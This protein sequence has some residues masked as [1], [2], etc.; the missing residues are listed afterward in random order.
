MSTQ[1]AN[2]R[3]ELLESTLGLLMLRTLVFGSQQ[4]QAIARAIQ[5]TP[6]RARLSLRQMGNLSN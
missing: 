5:Q 1:E 4:G 6:R 2:D 3:L